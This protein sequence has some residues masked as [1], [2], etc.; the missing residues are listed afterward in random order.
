MHLYEWKSCRDVNFKFKFN[1]VFWLT[2]K[3]IGF[4]YFEMILNEHR[5][6]RVVSTNKQ[7]KY[8]VISSS[9]VT[10]FSKNFSMIFHFFQATIQPT[11]VPFT[12]GHH[13][14]FGFTHS[15]FEFKFSKIWNF[16]TKNRQVLYKFYYKHR[17]LELYV[18]ALIS[19]SFN[20]RI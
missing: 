4:E 8:Y 18:K 5:L 16:K 12:R 20:S 15:K 19:Q 11:S 17:T 3:I 9:K 14:H 1:S 13:H 6:F 7:L 2:G 10:R